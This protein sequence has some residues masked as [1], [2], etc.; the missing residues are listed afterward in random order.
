VLLLGASGSGKTSVLKALAGLLSDAEGGESSGSVTIDGQPVS[1]APHRAG[2]VLQDPDSQVMLSRVGD[3][4]AFGCE[5]LG[6][7]A[8]DIPRRVQDAM[9]AVSLN[10]DL[11]HPTEQL[12]GGQKQRLALA[13]VLAMR[14][15]ALLLD[16]PTALLDPEGVR[17][18]RA[19]VEA[20]CHNRSSTVVIVEHRVDLW[21]NLVDRV[22]VLNADGTVVADGTP[23]QVITEQA[24]LLGELGVWLPGRQVRPNR[25][26]AFGHSE[27]VLQ[28]SDMTVGW[29]ADTPATRCPQVSLH[30]GRVLAITGPNGAGKTALA[31]TLG[32]LL[33]PLNGQVDAH[34]IAGNLNPDPNTWKSAELA[35][36]I[37]SVFQIPEHQFVAPTVRDELALSLTRAGRGNRMRTEQPEREA[38]QRIEEIAQRVGLAS[39]L[40]ANPFTLSGGEQRR[41]SV[42]TALIAAPSVL[43]LDE[44]TF[45]QDAKTWSDM[46]SLLGELRDQN[47]AIAIVTHDQQL[48]DTL[49]DEQLQ[50][51]PL[52]GSLA[53][54]GEDVSDEDQSRFGASSTHTEK[55]AAR[56]VSVNPLAKI[57]AAAIISLSLIFS[58]DWV[59]ASV[60]VALEL[61]L[62]FWAGLAPKKLLRTVAPV[63]IAASLTALTIMLYGQQSGTTYV[64]FLLINVSDGSLELAFATF[65]RVLAIALP[66]VVLLATVDPTDLADALEQHTRWSPRFILGA[67]VAFRLLTLIAADWRMITRARRARGLGN[68]PALARFWRQT[69]ALLVLSMRRADKL[70]TAMQAR[71]FGGLQPRSWSRTS[72]VG[73]A[74][75]MLVAISLAI[76][77]ASVS[78]SVITGNWNF[79]FGGLS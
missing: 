53:E 51:L 49:A 35:A 68:A 21:L 77:L 79:I 66:A 61:A 23:E 42:A 33:K 3:D 36:H 6:V 73:L 44:P 20:V 47:T 55:R 27:S 2:M 26:R 15:G 18:V 19:A 38:Q 29:Q 16:E 13:G 37:A 62:L 8:H 1:E 70:S 67:L 4:V 17:E 52:A 65:L 10:L 60:A 56:I 43:I 46:V 76:A 64:Q 22:I 58:L 25:G 78:L 63:M 30:P 7:P 71:G 5:N 9:T 45:G 69:F 75:W 32:G 40:S 31:L 14:P 12:S 54:R 24:V 11:D 34:L 48:I 57:A 74:E 28:A 72:T 39:L 41:L 50:L 59:S